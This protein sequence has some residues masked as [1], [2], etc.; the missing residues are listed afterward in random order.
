MEPKY[1][2]QSTSYT[3]T[4]DGKT[5]VEKLLKVQRAADKQPSMEY[6]VLENGK[7]VKMSKNP[8]EIRRLLGNTRSPK[9]VAS[10]HSPKTHASKKPKPP[11][12]KAT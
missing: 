11:K 8:N 5:K 6:K 10:K 4:Y 9:P 1:V 12:S 2:Y 3:M 7:T